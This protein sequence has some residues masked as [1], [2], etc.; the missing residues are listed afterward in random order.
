MSDTAAIHIRGRRIGPGEP[1]Y[2]IAELSANHGQNFERARDLV[3]IAAKAGADALKLQTY[4][5]DTITLD[6]DKPWFRIE[7]GKGTLWD[8]RN[9]HSL[10]R[11]AYTPWEWHAELKKEAEN[12]GLALFSSPFDPTAADFLEGLD[13]P[14]YKIA[15]FELVD[16]PLISYVASKGK[17]MIMSTGM[18]T[19]EEIDDAVRAA[20]EGGASEIAL[21]RCNSGYP[22]PPEEMDLATIPDMARR[23]SVPIGLSDHTLGISAVVASVALGACIIEKHFTLSRAEPGPDSAF[24][25]EPAEFKAMVASV[26][27][28]EKALGGVRYGPAHRERK[29]LQFRRS[30]FVV[31]DVKEG[32]CFTMENVRSIRPAN[33]IAPKHLGSILG[34]R[35][36]RDIER[37]TPLSWN[38]VAAWND[39]NQQDAKH[40]RP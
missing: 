32:E 8:G 14:A 7:Q 11:E 21:L 34:K 15:S 2:I 13:V 5:A 22:A 35:A 36:T 23:W 6:S 9:L 33:G 39:S 26:R 17:P 40:G 12:L 29:S 24:S 4:T 37:G 10:Y 25:L 19:A 1:A 38:L 31:E 16:L 27:D 28:A 30:L 18:A 20:R 3:H